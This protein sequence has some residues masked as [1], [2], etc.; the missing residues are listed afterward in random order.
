MK[1]NI[2]EW[3]DTTD[4]TR[5]PQKNPLLTTLISRRYLKQPLLGVAATA[6]PLLGGEETAAGAAPASLADEPMVD[7]ATVQAWLAKAGSPGEAD[8][9]TTSTTDRTKL[10]MWWATHTGE[11][12]ICK[13]LHDNGAA[14]DITKA[15]ADRNTPMHAACGNGRLPVCKWLFEVGAAKDITKANNYGVTPMYIACRNGH[16]SVCEWLFEVGAAKGITKVDIDG[17]TPILIA[18]FKGHLSVCKWLFEVGAAA[19]ISKV[20]NNGATPMYI[21]CH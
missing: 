1:K 18:C 7:D 15:N 3:K 14:A 20:D 8:E 13:W 5:K 6:A 11:L 19:D 2:R 12:G 21:A 9:G 16:L 4:S 17:T 10:P